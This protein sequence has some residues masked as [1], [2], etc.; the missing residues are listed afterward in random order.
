[1]RWED[2]V[3]KVEDKKKGNQEIR[4]KRFENIFKE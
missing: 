2:K 1:M 4:S 3:S